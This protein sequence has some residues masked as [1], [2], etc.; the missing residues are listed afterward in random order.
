MR[1]RLTKKAKILLTKTVCFIVAAAALIFA[2]AMIPTIARILPRM[3][4][5][6]AD[7]AYEGDTAPVFALTEESAEEPEESD[8]ENSEPDDESE[9][10]PPEPLPVPGEDDLPVFSQNLCWYGADETPGLYVINESRYSVELKD[11]VNRSFPVTAT[12][13]DEPIVLIM[14]THGSESYLESGYGFYSPDETFRS[15]DEDKTVVH[16]G[17]LLCEQLN[18]LGIPTLHD[19]T[20]YDIEDFNSSYTYSFKGIKQWLSDYPSIKF[21]IDLHRDSIFDSDGNNVKPI[22]EIDGESVAQIMV[23]TGTDQGTVSH[24]NWKNNLTFSAYLQQKLCELYPT[25]ARPVNVR[26]S[27]FNQQLTS[28]SILLEVG[29]C[30]NTIDEA[31]RAIILFARAYA[32]VLK[33]NLS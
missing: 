2:F 33:E 5:A 21:V 26:T 3:L 22:T 19:D 6:S 15:T 9:S 32:D 13:T 30:G 14:H 18:S 10:E 1:I 28:G 4:I 16:I 31:E 17:E 7:V 27:A 20:M 12:I 25:L 23:V 8:T 29:S 11:Y 24:P